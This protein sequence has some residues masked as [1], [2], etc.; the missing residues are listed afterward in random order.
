M[1]R[2]A[3]SAHLLALAP[4][5][6]KVRDKRSESSSLGFGI[7]DMSPLL[8]G[9]RDL[10]LHACTQP[11]CSKAMQC[12]SKTCSIHYLRLKFIAEHLHM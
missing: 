6:V 11:V 5:D 4:K 10:L 2:A 3:L 12:S 1:L 7:A 9:R 8:A